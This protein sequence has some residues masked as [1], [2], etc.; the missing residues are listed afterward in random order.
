MIVYGNI[1]E[2]MD[3]VLIEKKLDLVDVSFVKMSFNLL[4]L[5]Y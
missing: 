1:F 2:C 4:I 5:R 3:E